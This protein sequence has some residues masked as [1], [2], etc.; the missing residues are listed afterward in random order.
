ML[1]G[2]ALVRIGAWFD[3]LGR[4][5]G[6]HDT[7]PVVQRETGIVGVGDTAIHAPCGL[8]AHPPEC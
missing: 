7:D 4:G 5:F 8:A 6:H 2:K 1:V 3:T